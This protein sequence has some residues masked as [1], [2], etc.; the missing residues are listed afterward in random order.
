[1]RNVG[2][3]FAGL[4]GSPPE[5][6][7]LIFLGLLAKGGICVS[8][9]WL[10]LTHSESETPVSAM[11]SGVVVKAGLYPLIRCA[12]MVS[13]VDP[14]V[15]LCGV[16]TALLGVGYA[17]FEKDSK[18]M[19]AFQTVSQLGFVLAAPEV[20]G[21][22][23]LTHGLVKSALFL[24]SGAAPSRNLIALGSWA[25]ILIFIRYRGLL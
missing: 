7:A 14:I 10:P 25:V 21:F 13:E 24:I 17:V 15:H 4:E 11:L 2:F 6:I 20:G 9:L 3:S 12:L 1:M 18:R 5:A 8:G 23:A 19:L 22:Y 16:G